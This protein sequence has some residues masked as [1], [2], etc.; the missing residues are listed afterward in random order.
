MTTPD[1]PKPSKSRP[2]AS[3]LDLLKS[4]QAVQSNSLPLTSSLPNAAMH[5]LQS[6]PNTTNN[7]A[8]LTDLLPTSANLSSAAPLT[9]LTN[10]SPERAH[11]SSEDAL[12]ARSQ[13]HTAHIDLKTLLDTSAKEPT[14]Q[15]KHKRSKT[16]PRQQP[17]FIDKSPVP[18]PVYESPKSIYS[19]TSP[20]LAES[21]DSDRRVALSKNSANTTSSSA[22]N[23]PK[24]PSPK[25]S[26]TSG[27]S[28]T[29][30]QKAKGYIKKAK[31]Y[32][33]STDEQLVAKLYQ[34]ALWYCSKSEQ[35]TALLTA[36][37]QKAL[38]DWSIPK[39][40]HSTITQS[41]V[42]KLISYNYLNDERYC[43]GYLRSRFGKKALKTLL[44]ELAFKG[45]P[46]DILQTC[47]LAFEPSDDPSN[48]SNEDPAA[49]QVKALWVSK[50]K[51]IVPERSDT[52]GRNKQM[53]FFASRGFAL[54]HLFALWKN[55]DPNY[56]TG[57][58]DA[59]YM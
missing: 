41:V 7:K 59:G 12:L 27:N 11:H 46:K 19:K 43:M 14:A 3:L 36:K 22:K 30:P 16:R 54:S 5:S 56:P 50:F 4:R 8:D 2:A 42:D 57:D 38:T 34:R 18:A 39:E 33:G 32:S 45:A 40:R 10:H 28:S 21:N 13:I 53:R 49:A 23:N 20:S 15:G 52:K 1:D 35:L 37:L 48:A 9:T 55:T 29:T 47:S 51:S 44:R 6:D 58:D 17:S 26:S 25:N 24:Q 31:D